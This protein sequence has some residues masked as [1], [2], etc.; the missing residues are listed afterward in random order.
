MSAG[1]IRKA[2]I[3]D[4]INHRVETALTERQRLIINA[5]LDGADAGLST[6]RYAKLADCSLDTALRDIKLLV[7]AGVL[8]TGQGGGRS[9][10]Y[11]LQAPPPSSATVL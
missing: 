4:W 5:L 11:Q 1:I 2:A 8:A 10:K 7:E 3:W 6:S 9:T